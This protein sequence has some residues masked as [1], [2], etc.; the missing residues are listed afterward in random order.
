[1]SSTTRHPPAYL[2]P[3]VLVQGDKKPE[4]E[5]DEEDNED[6][7]KDHRRRHSV[8]VLVQR[9]V[10][11]TEG[12]VRE[13]DF[14]HALFRGCNIGVYGGTGAQRSRPT[15][16]EADRAVVHGGLAS[17]DGHVREEVN[18]GGSLG[19]DGGRQGVL[20]QAEE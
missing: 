3:K 11:V 19:G 12:R 14:L 7:A 15:E 9:C 10:G 5:C 17:E 8:V 4:T 20:V 16:R 2:P 6:T 18:V 13:W 1:M